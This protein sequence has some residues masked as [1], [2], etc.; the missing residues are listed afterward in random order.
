M[1]YPMVHFEIA[2]QLFEEPSPEF[3]LGSIAPDSIHVRTNERTEKNK[4]H[5]MKNG[6]FATNRDLSDFLISIKNND[7][8]HLEFICGYIAHIYTDREWTFKV[9]SEF[10]KQSKDKFIYNHDANKIEFLLRQTSGS[11]DEILRK[12]NTAK[13][14]DIAGL[15]KTEILTY[16]DEKVNYLLEPLNEPM[17]APKIITFT[18][19]QNFIKEASSGLK[20]LFEEQKNFSNRKLI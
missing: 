16:K 3:L 4:T 17:N 1:P 12:L 9:Y 13:S 6:A 10:E 5:L 19:V 8:L 2:R 7:P 15:S 20:S 18:M 11:F 14:Y